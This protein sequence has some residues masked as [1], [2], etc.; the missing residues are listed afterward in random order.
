MLKLY[1]HPLSSFCW[2]VLIPLYESGI[3]FEPV[4]VN[5]GDPAAR[6]EYL[7]LSPFGKIPT[8]VDGERV[9]NET[10]IMIEYLALTYPKAA[11]LVPKESAL[12]LSL[13]VD[14]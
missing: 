8:L 13:P 4:M 1:L 12:S 7:K 5:L 9:V 10:S 3:P 2:K 6:A 14:L 11:G